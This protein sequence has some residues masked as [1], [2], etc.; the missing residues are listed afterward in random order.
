MSF[1]DYTGRT[2][3]RM[4]KGVSG[5]TYGN[6]LLLTAEEK[7]A[8]ALDGVVAFTRPPK[9]APTQE[10]LEARRK[11]AIRSIAMDRVSYTILGDLDE[12]EDRLTTTLVDIVMAVATLSQDLI[13]KGLVNNSDYSTRVKEI[14]QSA[15]QM[16]NAKIA[17]VNAITNGD[18]VDT[19][20]TALDLIIPDPK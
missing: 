8:A 18:T 16:R 17:A 14:R 15:V 5:I 1:Q 12:G 19:F 10:Y 4:M 3:T 2:G 20:I 6:M 11:R 7:A 13:A 9:P